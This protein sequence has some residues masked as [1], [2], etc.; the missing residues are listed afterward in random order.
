M[1]ITALILAAGEGTRMRSNHAKVMHML[2]DRPLIWWAAESCRKAGATRLV[3]VVGH[4]QQEIRDYFANIDY[5]RQVDELIFVEQTEQLGTG[6]AVLCAKKALGDFTGPV[7]VIYGDTPLLRPETIQKLIQTNRTH[8]N[9]CT[10]LAMT[11]EN[12][13]GY[14]RLVVEDGKIKAIIEEKD[15]TEE[16]RE[17][18]RVCN[19]GVYC[20]CGRRL[21]SYI[22]NLTCKN[23]QH[24]YYITDM[25]GIFNDAGE[26]VLTYVCEDTEE[27]LGVNTRAQL[28]DATAIMQMRINTHWMQEGVS[29]LDPH[30]VWIGADVTLGTDCVLLPQT[31]LWGRTSVG[32]DCTIG[33]SSRLTN[34][35]VGNGCTIDETIIV[36]SC[37]DNSVSCGPRA[38]IRGG[39]HLMNSSKAGTHVEIKGSTVGEGSKVP[40]LSYIGDATIGSNTNIGGGSITC[41][42]DGKHKSH[43]E[44]GDHVFIGSDTM[45]VAPVTIGD[46]ALIG[47][48]SCITKDVPTGAL[49][50]E[51]SKLLIK[52]HWA[53]QYWDKL[54]KED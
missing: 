6:H 31:F 41:N 35:R 8:H 18:L 46:N 9:A 26:E 33:P 47:A 51:R 7:V 32:N 43:T 34:A 52:E 37:V 16:Q 40:H 3:I 25:V 30:Q 2:L 27:T 11:P 19:S 29:M 44:I 14:G 49:A 42:Y 15:C 23:A 38:Y 17:T 54:Q 13:S 50:L 20:F 53:E 10:T 39:A 48:S 24:E 45:M 5:A 28:A 22:E 36:D 21:S 4:K 1:P 12:P